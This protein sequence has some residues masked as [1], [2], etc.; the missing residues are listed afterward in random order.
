[1]SGAVDV[2]GDGVDDVLI[3]G[4]GQAYSIPGDGPKTATGS[5]RTGGQQA[6]EWG[7]MRTLGDLDSLDD[8]G[9]TQFDAGDDDGL[10]IGPWGDINDDGVEDFIIGAPLADTEGGVD[11]GKA[12]F[13]FGS[14]APGGNEVRP[15]SSSG[16]Y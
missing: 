14:L 1:M 6:M 15:R 8:F 3:A 7:M 5:S 12:Y 10:C 9:G 16:S 13:V 2:N 4:N 11:A